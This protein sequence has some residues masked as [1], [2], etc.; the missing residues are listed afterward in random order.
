MKTIAMINQKGGVGK[1]TST[2]N[3]GIALAREGK[4]VLLVDA[5]PQG[6]LTA[7]L[8]CKQPFSVPCTLYNLVEKMVA[9]QPITSEAGILHNEEN[10]DYIPSHLGL[11]SMEIQLA[12]AW[13]RE[14]VFK[15][16][17]EPYQDQ[18]DY[19][20]IDCNPS[21][22]LYPVNALVAADSVI[23]PVQPQPFSIQGLNY[24]LNSI[25]SARQNIN[26]NLVIDG[27]LLT[28]VDR[29]TNITK[30][31]ANMLRRTYGRNIRIFNAQIP[32]DAKLKE[33]TAVSK[34]IFAY[35]PGSKS[36][37]AYNLLA[38]EVLTIGREQSVP[39]RTG[40]LRI[41]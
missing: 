32:V 40:E 38:K 26:H 37:E 9:G 19:C 33:S 15:R 11:S 8:G 21:L 17:L 13:S 35:A 3:L 31:S 12:S 1:T 29:V 27:I 10:V 23:I 14:T 22:G 16:I 28:M 34:S 18:Y 6:N 20:V 5:D 25:A 36:A 7:Y 2:M 4:K 39:K 24:Q 30:D 41:R